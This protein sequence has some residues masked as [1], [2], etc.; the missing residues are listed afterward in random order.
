MA[1][2]A[3]CGLAGKVVRAIAPQSESD[4]AAVLIQFL[5]AAGNLIGRSYYYRVEGDHH[6]ANL[7]TVLVGTS[8]KARKGTSWGRV[9]SIAKVADQLW[10]ED[11]VKG[12]LSSGEGF[13]SEVR[14]QTANDPGVIDKR[15]LIVEP[16]FAAA[17]AVME[18]HG[19]ILSP[20]I[21]RAWD[22]DKLATLTRTAPLAATD[23]HISIIGHITETEL[24]ARLTRIDA[25]NGF[26]NRFLFTLVRRSK[27]LPFGGNL[28]E[29]DAVGLGQDLAEVM[30]K[31]PKQPTRIDMVGM[32]VRGIWEEV[33]PTLSAEHD[34][35]FGAVTARAEAQTVRLAMIYAI[36]DGQDAIGVPHL[37]AALAVWDYS[38]KSAKHIFGDKSGDPVV[39]DV[40]AAL[41]RAGDDGVTRTQI[42]GLFSGHQSSERISAALEMLQAKGLARSGTKSTGGRPV[43]VWY[44]K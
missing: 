22:G 33:Y 40:L 7:F 23:A 6:H 38:E 43:E 27:L 11:R 3:Y 5:S 9:R 16:E 34:G 35:L 30:A 42:R 28:T 20:M 10:A 12:G 37:N 14:D 17:L 39:D 13:I 31:L 32:D 29:V 25:A 18:R 36:L 24:R 4:P 1:E 26:A 19:N 41:D 15:L 2:E 21:R 44:A 8:A